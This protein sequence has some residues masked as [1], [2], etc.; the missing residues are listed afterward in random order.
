MASNSSSSSSLLLILLLLMP[1]YHGYQ[2]ADARFLLMPTLESLTRANTDLDGESEYSVEVGDDNTS[3]SYTDGTLVNNEEQVASVANNI[4]SQ[5]RT[6]CGLNSLSSDSELKGIATQHAS[7]IQYVFANAK[8]TQFNPHYENE[9]ADIIGVTGANNP[10]FSGLDFKARALNLDYSNARFG[11]TENIAQTFYYHSAGDLISADAAVISMSKSLLAAPYHL[12]SLMLP[13]S[14]LTATSVVGYKPFNKE[15]ANN[16]G[17]VLVNHA[18][19]TRSSVRQSFDG[20]FTYPCEGVINTVTALYNEIPDPVRHTGRNLQTDPIGQP[21]YVNVPSAK[22]IRIMNVRFYDLQRS[23]SV[24]TQILDYQ[25]DPYRNSAYELPEN[26]AFILPITDNLDSC[27]GIIRRAKNCG[28]HGNSSYQ[29]SFDILVD[30]QSMQSQSF[31][32]TTGEVN[33]S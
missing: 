29:V 22:S 20:V 9:I 18:S 30:N 32:F 6:N 8:P 13:S 7:Y 16:Q 5:A 10:F 2:Q 14:T 4:F 26:E 28:L 1:A 23:V 27:K 12:R 24:P 15:P 17:Y 31:S 25:Q 19:G 3:N 21:I 11:M 33:Y